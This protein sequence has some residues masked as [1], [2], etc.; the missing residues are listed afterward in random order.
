MV[1]LTRVVGLSHAEVAER[2]GRSEGAT[3]MLLARALALLARSMPSS[4]S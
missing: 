4:G 3:R 2:L 1:L